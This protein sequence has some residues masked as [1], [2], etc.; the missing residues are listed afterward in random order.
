MHSGLVN[1]HHSTHHVMGAGLG[2]RVNTR[3][4]IMIHIIDNGP[5]QGSTLTMKGYV[6]GHI[7]KTRCL[8][9]EKRVLNE[10][11]IAAMIS[12]LEIAE[13]AVGFLADPEEKND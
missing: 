3:D 1:H 11:D 7:I 12:W 6:A 10:N 2:C 13:E 5:V 4:A 8:L 9:Q